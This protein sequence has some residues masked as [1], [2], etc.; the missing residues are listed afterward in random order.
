MRYLKKYHSGLH[1]KKRIKNDG[2]TPQYYVK[3]SHEAIIPRDIFIQVQEEIECR[4]HLLSGDKVKRV[5]LN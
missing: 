3:D 4:T 1:R 2:T 5:Y